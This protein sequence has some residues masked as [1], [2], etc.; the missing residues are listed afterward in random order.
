MTCCK[1]WSTI[2][3][4]PTLQADRTASVKPCWRR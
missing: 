4:L 2:C 1:N 3:I